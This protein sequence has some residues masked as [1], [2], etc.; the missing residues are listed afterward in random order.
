MGEASGQRS[1]L[2]QLK[3][4]NAQFSII[5]VKNHLSV[6]VIFN[7]KIIFAHTGSDTTLFKLCVMDISLL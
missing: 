7:L 2:I 6:Q 1:L 5:S 3:S 4:P